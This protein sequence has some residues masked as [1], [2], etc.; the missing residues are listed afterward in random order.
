VTRSTTALLLCCATFV[1]ACA[2]GD[3]ADG[4]DD[5]FL[6][7]G[8]TDDQRV[9][10]GSDEACAVL[11]L[12][13]TATEE[14]L[15]ADV[16]LDT[17][18]ARA[19]AAA[20]RGADGVRDTE[21]DGW[22]RTL[23]ELDAVKYVGPRA[24]AR[25]LAY[26]EAR[27]VAC[28]A[29]EVQLLAFNDFHGNLKPPSGSSA[30]IVTGPD[31]A[32]DRVDAGGA[33]FM[34]THLRELRAANPNTLVVSAGDI[35]GASPLLSAAFHDEPTIEAMNAMDL[36]ITSVGNHEFDEGLAELQRMQHG[37]CHGGAGCFAAR[38][39]EGARF[40]YLAANV[41]EEA[42]GETVF[43]P[44]AIRRFGGARVAFIGMT[45]EGTPLVTTQQGV[46]GLRFLDEADT[47]N[48]LV[49]D[50]RARGIEAIVVLLHEGG[51]ATGLYSE[52]VGV[53]G[54]V[55]EIAARL[56]PA[57]DVIVSG[58][59][60]AAH[61]CDVGGKLV[62]SAASFGRLITDIDLT[63][64]ERTGE[65]TAR[66]AR[67]VIVTRDVE[68]DPVQTALIAAWDALV[69]PIA[70]RVVG[71]IVTDLTKTPSAAGETPL[72][73]LIADAHLLATRANGA[74]IAFMNPGGVRAD[75][76]ASQI[77][78]GE[79]AGEITFGELFAVQPFGNN[80]VTLAVTGAQLEQLLEQQWQ[81]VGG[82]E[83]ANILAPSAGF[84][85]AW[86][87]SRPL[88]DRVDPASM[89]LDGQ[90]IDPARTYRVTV[91]S[92]VADG[93]D[94][95]AVMKQ[96]TGRS[97]G[98]VDLDPLEAWLAARSPVAPPSL[99]RITRLD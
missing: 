27:G 45:L 97:P 18:A 30:R 28:G 39:F 6:T 87:A 35:I 40:S 79:Q 20:R 26:T 44:I 65:V 59:T 12:A 66:R 48:R 5:P 13:N 94:G 36:A 43:P 91:N 41:I 69:A 9:V 83:K 74:Q 60:N 82:A 51:A 54:P 67:N 85:Y 14:E 73:D 90:P 93:G 99:E 52:C 47:V 46:Q 89:R 4:I 53:S 3:D 92:F 24:F 56:D 61:V 23:A 62:T 75:L 70:N 38:G 17:R 95:F 64:D 10:D 34:A 32:V 19:I 86:S 98:P 76:V 58:H 78:G 57:V 2:S 84:T 33:E 16:G 37:G 25:L 15:D 81:L 80:L 49:P 68:R 50:L 55:F 72:G 1:T 7:P 88:G 63:L 42:T 8:K 11:E 71:R 96:G 29:V 21:D 22:F 77:S 31:P